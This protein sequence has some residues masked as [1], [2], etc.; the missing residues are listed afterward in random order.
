[1]TSS[2]FGPWFPWL[3]PPERDAPLSGDVSQ[4]LRIFSPTVTVQGRGE[5]AL[6]GEIVREVAT[7]GAQLG[8]ITDIVI[9]LAEGE[10]VP[11]EALD[12]LKDIRREITEKKA[13]YQQGARDRARKALQKLAEQDPLSLR[14]LLA[15]FA[16]PEQDSDATP[17]P[18]R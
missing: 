12:K 5:P 2:W 9:A 14:A 3:N 18:R 6:E 15:E 17:D 13:D 16:G 8:P 1:M 10:P 11:N 7:Y 4:W